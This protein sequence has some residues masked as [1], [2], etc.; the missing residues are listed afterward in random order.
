[1][2]TE[3]DG[4]YRLQRFLEDEGA[5]CRR[6]SCVTAWLLYNVWQIRFDTNNRAGAARCSDTDESR[7]ENL[8]NG[9]DVAKANALTR[10][11][12]IKR[13]AYD[14]FQVFAH[15][16]GL[17]DYHLPDMG[18]IAEVSRTRSTTTTCAAARATWRS[19]S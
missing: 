9:V 5:E 13:P 19:A 4:N 14:V 10:G 6:Y 18:E 1:M 11:W 3:G 12:P 8:A 15:G 16:L 2:T 17:Y 7:F